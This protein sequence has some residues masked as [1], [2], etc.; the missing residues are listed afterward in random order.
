MDS[1]FTEISAESKVPKIGIFI[2]CFALFTLQY[3]APTVQQ[4][5]GQPHGVAHIPGHLGNVKGIEIFF[6]DDGKYPLQIVSTTGN[7]SNKNEQTRNK[8]IQVN[9]LINLKIK[10]IIANVKEIIILK[11]FIFGTVDPLVLIRWHHQQST[12]YAIRLEIL[13]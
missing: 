6:P 11:L 7:A 4:E 1:N 10:G 9:Q 12:T 5:I 13:L 3:Q 8:G 2:S